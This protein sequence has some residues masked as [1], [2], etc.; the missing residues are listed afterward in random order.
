MV[1]LNEVEISDGSDPHLQYPVMT[2]EWNVLQWGEIH[3]EHPC[4]FAEFYIIAHSW[5]CNHFFEV[6]LTS[7]FAEV[8]L[9]RLLFLSVIKKKLHKKKLGSTHNCDWFWVPAYETYYSWILGWHIDI[10]NSL[11]MSFSICTRNDYLYILVS[12]ST[13]FHIFY[14]FQV[15]Q[16]YRY[17][18]DVHMQQWMIGF[19]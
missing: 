6:F 10:I 7:N 4:F 14:F 15:E 3:R 16:V 18:T 2:I 12:G 9:M 11:Q 13:L 8:N 19:A 5:K 17:Q 1:S